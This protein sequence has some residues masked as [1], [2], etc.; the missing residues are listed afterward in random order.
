MD[1][2]KID[3][4]EL[5]KAAAID[6]AQAELAPQ[7]PWSFAIDFFTAIGLA[8][9]GF[10]SGKER[11]EK[12]QQKQKAQDSVENYTLD[13]LSTI[14]QTGLELVKAG[15]QP[16]TEL[17]EV[18][19]KNNLYDL[20]GYRGN[21]EAD[22]WAPNTEV[23]VGKPERP[24]WFTV[25]NN[26]AS[27]SIAPALIAPGNLSTLWFNTCRSIRDGWMQAYINKLRAEGKEAQIKQIQSDYFNANV[28]Y[29][30]FFGGLTS[31]LLITLLIKSRKVA[32]R[33]VRR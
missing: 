9:F 1:S 13:V 11:Q 21:C 26:G 32:K 2:P 12:Q 28:I 5:V 18:N 29:W 22:V 14:N 8:V 4:E 6:K 16:G 19:L 25:R 20:V 27:L 7:S 30:I 33:R 10:V 23:S 17:F 24:I 3:T 31:V 15:L